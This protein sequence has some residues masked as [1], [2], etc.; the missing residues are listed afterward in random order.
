MA[1]RVAG[2]RVALRQTCRGSP[3]NFFSAGI[4]RSPW[5]AAMAPG[6]GV[7]YGRL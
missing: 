5:N 6:G 2:L 1:A 3:E 4:R 7:S